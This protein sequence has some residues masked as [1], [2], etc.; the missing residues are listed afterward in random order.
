MGDRLGTPGV[1]D[2]W[3]F[4]KSF[5]FLIF[6]EQILTRLHSRKKW[7]NIK[8]GN[9]Q[10]IGSIF[11]VVAIWCQYMTSNFKFIPTCIQTYIHISMPIK[12]SVTLWC[13]ILYSMLTEAYTHSFM[14]FTCIH[15]YTHK[16]IHIIYM[17]NMHTYIHTYMH[18]WRTCTHTTYTKNMDTSMH[19][20]VI[21]KFLLI[22]L[23]LWK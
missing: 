23:W 6:Q 22:I 18:T 17:K 4:F 16:F 12:F 20:E 3:F 5:Q 10:K 8:K 7:Q 19:W 14:E 21:F 9:E 2:F 11:D 15:T 13:Q 1:V